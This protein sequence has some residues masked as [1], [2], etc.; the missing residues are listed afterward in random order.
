VTAPAVEPIPER[1]SL[2]E[3]P[4]PGLLLRLYRRRASGALTLARD[5]VEKRIWL[6]QGAPVLSESNLASE[7]LGI[8]LLDAGRITREDYARVVAAMRER[9]G[10]EGAALLA[11][12]LVAPRELYEALKQQVRRRVLDCLGWTR[13]SFAF[14]ADAAPAADAT[15]FR[16]DPIPLVHEGVA[17]HWNAAALRA[18]LGAA[19]DRYAA[20]TPRADA[21]A[22]RLYRDAEVDR[23][24]EALD[25]TE[26]LG[27][28][29]DAASGPTARAALYVLSAAGGL[30]LRDE[31]LLRA[32]EGE[33]EEDAPEI[34][35]VL[36]GAAPGPDAAASPR[37]PGAP[38]PAAKSPARGRG[39]DA[40][41]SLREEIATVHAALGT[42]D[43]YALLGL[44]RA[45]DP[46]AVRRAYLL[47]AK[48]FHPDAVARQGLVEL[49]EAAEAIFARIA[50]AHDVL[51]DPGRR[52]D[53]DRALA[54]GADD[55][56][57]ARLVQGETLYRK[58]EVLLRAGNF[59]G[60]LEFLR[61]AV[62]L[63]PDEGAYQSALGW[64]LYK[65]T[66][67]E[68]KPA[69]EHLA[70]AVALDRKDAIAHFRLGLALRALG[71]R[72]EAE[73]ALARARVL[74]PTVR[75]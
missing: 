57:V 7:S 19:C 32:A 3:I 49:R 62:A 2:E 75:S 27:A 4:L 5:G 43:H 25:G 64:A 16:C 17:I 66:P 47:A 23:I 44:D 33:G 21:L 29:L 22:S 37:G 40:S 42:R 68:P 46:P 51:S 28:L 61:P 72:E 10:R 34:E 67:P 55:A 36:A 54:G 20:A 50:E 58:G 59:A 63:C 38:R 24:L 52:L 73:R 53:Y 69:R 8:Q 6:R 31:P 11:L 1:G 12:E 74:D 14:E 71:E 70:R 13:G 35:V 45:A 26:R 41:A 60:A 15:A 18:A 56:E 30:A 48:R 9:G 65:K 39:G